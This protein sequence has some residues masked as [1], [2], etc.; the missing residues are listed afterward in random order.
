MSKLIKN[1]NM[2]FD[3]AEKLYEDVQPYHA[4]EISKI[5]YQLYKSIC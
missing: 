2:R 4:N 3:L 5:R 1:P